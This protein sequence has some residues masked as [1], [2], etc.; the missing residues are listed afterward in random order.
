MAPENEDYGK[1]LNQKET[2]KILNK[3]IISQ[4]GLKHAVH[5]NS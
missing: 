1:E 2:D 4:I 5:L 3:E